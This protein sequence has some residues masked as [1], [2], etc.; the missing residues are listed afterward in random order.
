FPWLAVFTYLFSS[1]VRAIARTPDSCSLF[2]HLNEDEFLNVSFAIVKSSICWNV[3][4]NLVVLKNDSQP[5]L[6]T[7]S[8]TLS[9]F[10][11]PAMY[12]SRIVLIASVTSG[13]L[14]GLF[15]R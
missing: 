3:N 8:P 9:C 2:Y 13:H 15:F 5:I 10:F 4:G 12:A 7:H 11:A 6:S 14:G 1:G